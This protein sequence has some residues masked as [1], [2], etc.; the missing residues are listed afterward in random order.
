MNKVFRYALLIMVLG[1]VFSV[2]CTNILDTSKTQKAP[3]GMG[4]FTLN[5]GAMSFGATILPVTVQGDFLLYTLFFTSDGKEDILLERTN[6]DL[7]N[8]ILLEVGIWDLEVTAFLDTEKTKS[9]AR[10]NLEFE[11]TSGSNVT[12]NLELEAII[13]TGTTGTFTWNINYPGDVT[14]ASMTITPL[15]EETGE[16]LYFTGPTPDIGKSGSRIM[17]TGYYLIVFELNNGARVIFR[18]EYLHVYQNLDS[19]FEYTFTQDHFTVRSVTSGADSGTGTLRHA[20]ANA[21]ANSTI[22]IEDSVNTISLSSR[23]EIS[24]NLSI[25]GNGVTLTRSG[26]WAAEN[27]TSQLLYISDA[28]V[29]L[30]RLHFKNGRATSYGAAIR[31]NGGTITLES[32]IF[33]GNS[34]SS[35]SAMGG[36]VYNDGTIY[37]KGCTFYENSSAGGGGAVYNNNSRIL[38]LTGNLFFG[39]SAPNWPVV[40]YSGIVSSGGY[41][42]ADKALGTGAGM[43]GWAEVPGDATISSRP[44]SP[45]TFRLLS[46]QGAEHVIPLTPAGYPTEDFYGASISSGAAA[47]AVQATAAGFY[48]DLTVNSGLG[49]V[50]VLSAP[51]ADGLYSG[52]VSISAS[53]SPPYELVYWL[54]DGREK[55]VSPSLTFTINYHTSIQAIFARAVTVDNFSDGTGSATTAGTLRY[56]LT[57]VQNWDLIRFSGVTAGQTSIG[58]TSAL[59]QIAAGITVIIEGNGAALARSPSWAGESNTSQLLYI[60]HSAAALSISGLHFKDGRAASYGAAIRQDSGSLSLESCIFSGNSTSSPSATGGAVYSAGTLDIKGCT[61]YGNSSGGSGGAVYSAGNLDIT[62]NLFYGNSAPNW[63]ILNSGAAVSSGGYNAADKVLGAGSGMSGWAAAPEDKTINELPVSP[64]SFRLLSGREAANAI[65]VIPW[66]YPGKDFYGAS[67]NSGAAAG[68][69][70]ATAAGYYVELI[71]NNSSLGTASLSAP[72]SDGCYLSTV[73]LTAA[74]TSPYELAYLL[75]NRRKTLL[76]NPLTITLNGH[77]NIEAVFAKIITIEDFS[78]TAGSAM[79]PTLRYALTNA[80]DWDLIRFGGNPGTSR[81]IELLSALPAITRRITIEGNGATLTRSPSWI[82]ANNSSQLLYI[83]HGNALVMIDGLH[84][85]D[86]VATSYGAAIRLDSGSLTLESCVFSGNSTNSGTA[87]GG[88]V[89]SNGILELKGCTFIRNSSGY[90]GGAIYNNGGT[91]T[92]TGNLFSENSASAAGPVVYRASGT[93]SSGG[94]N[95]VDISYGTGA[96]QCGWE[97]AT[98]D[99]NS[100]DWPVSLKTFRLLS[101]S[102]AANTISAIPKGYPTLDFYGASINPGAAAGAVQS[103][104][105]GSGFYLDLSINNKTLGSVSVSPPP[106][107][108]GIVPSSVTLSAHPDTDYGLVYWLKNGIRDGYSSSLGLTLAGHTRVLAVFGFIISNFN[109]TPGITQGTLRYALNNIKDGDVIWLDGVTP[110]QTSI[111]LTSALPIIRTTLTIEG[112]GAVLTRDPSWTTVGPSTQLLQINSSSAV[113]NITRLHFKDG[114]AS[115]YGGAI[116][117]RGNLTLESCILSGNG[118]TTSGSW[119]G[120][121]Y[122]EGSLIARGCTFYNNSTPF[123]GGAI[124]IRSGTLNLTGN[125]FY[126]NTVS[127]TEGA[128]GPNVYREAGTASSGGYNRYNGSAGWTTVTTDATVSSLPINTSTFAPVSSLQNVLP[129]G[130][131]ANFPAMD[132]YGNTRTWPGAPGAVNFQ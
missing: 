77:T 42:L 78:D 58:L 43:S 29:S 86:G 33:S 2:G 109:D 90:R 25:A 31:N 62:G 97:A 53:T 112:N 129:S 37:I 12:K 98:G 126:G 66:G 128:G 8:S 118:T 81:V 28:T 64:V 85:R 59:P 74:P 50:D 17:D 19:I 3:A 11:I 9:A 18:E 46:G 47:G 65:D 104:A 16:L 106:D 99:K 38:T 40:R 125:I 105:S 49:T 95:A 14:S 41:N 26:S 89:Y 103:A 82:A 113:V 57:N 67:I 108:D 68:A 13:E 94:Y 88:A 100:G 131:I 51:N 120:A 102:G 130:G 32:C 27:D 15:D 70:Q 107:I 93:V 44:A 101:G 55:V 87:M 119:G 92:L 34:T 115:D 76:P 24:K 45:V 4:F 83:N 63:P 56:A 39:N 123:R 1:A 127:S 79:D 124:Y 61:F 132:F 48:L 72:N 36:A 23:L 60:N 20:I 7:G 114:E 111:A 10:A 30:G 6:A 121:I 75:V 35:P 22:Y 52:S 110:G 116:D 80:N 122:T 117:N 5:A 21:P 96:A 69:V 54:K 84:F 91:L 73:T 71:S